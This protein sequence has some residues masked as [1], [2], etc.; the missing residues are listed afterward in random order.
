MGNFKIITF[1]DTIP[2][3][4]ILQRFQ[5]IS[6]EQTHIDEGLIDHSYLGNSFVKKKVSIAFNEKYLLF[7]SWC[8]QV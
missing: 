2:N 5:M 4:M 6:T 8:F 1:P 3:N 7:R